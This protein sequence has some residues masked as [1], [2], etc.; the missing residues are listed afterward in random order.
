[1]R[2]ALRLRPLY[3]PDFPLRLLIRNFLLVLNTNFHKILQK[4]CL[5]YT[6]VLFAHSGSERAKGLGRGKGR[7]K[8]VEIK[9]PKVFVRHLLL[10]NIQEDI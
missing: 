1:M 9:R 10:S 6:S 4:K 8:K 7:D 5:I 3:T 2:L